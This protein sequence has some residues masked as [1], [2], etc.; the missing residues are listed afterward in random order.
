MHKIQEM[1]SGKTKNKIDKISR[2][3]YKNKD[4]LFKFFVYLILIDVAFV[5]LYP[6]IY[7]VVASLK[8]AQDFADPYTYWIIKQPTLEN[9][10]D[11]YETMSF[12]RSATNSIIIAL[13]SSIAQVISCSFIGY[14]FARGKF[15]GRDLLFILALFTLIVPPQTIIVSLFILYQ[16]LNWIDTYYPFIIP[17]LFGQGLKGALFIYI[18]RQ[19]F[20]GFPQEL[21]DAARIDGAGGI[22][23][24]SQVFLPLSK[25]AIL[26]VSLFSFVWHWNDYFEFSIYIMD[27][28]KATLPI[29]LLDLNWW[30]TEVKMGYGGATGMFQLNEGVEMAGCLLVIAIP[31]ILYAFAQ[32]YFVSSIERTGLVG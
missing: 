7:M 25:P 32:K 29:K 10:R 28:R 6:L 16:R 9:L 12:L 8:T 23:I 21:E 1:F 30:F 19:F 11:A 27:K 2:F 17:S 20:K 26:V 5:F 3:G 22:R 13:A 24:Y 4:F 31:L 18:F 15:P 14:G